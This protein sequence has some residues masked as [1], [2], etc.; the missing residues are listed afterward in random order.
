MLFRSN[1]EKDFN[2]GSIEIQQILL[3][4][5]KEKILLLAFKEYGRYV[6]EIKRDDKRVISTIK[7]LMEEVY[8][9]DVC[10]ISGELV[11]TLDEERFSV[12]DFIDIAIDCEAIDLEEA[13][14]FKNY[15]KEIK[16]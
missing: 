6:V 10:E 1:S 9:C 11:S 12:N 5:R 3:E 4:L 13:N 16:Y 2:K 8:D 14:E 15:L 7:Q